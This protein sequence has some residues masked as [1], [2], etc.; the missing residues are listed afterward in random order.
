MKRICARIIF[1]PLPVEPDD[2]RLAH[3][4]SDRS[5]YDDAR[6]DSFEV[7]FR[8]GDGF[9]TE[10]SWTSLSVERGGRLLTPPLER[11]LLP[12]VLRE[13]LLAEGR[14]EERD[15]GL[16]DLRGGFYIGNAVRGLIAAELVGDPR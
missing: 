1:I 10:G 15:L 7:L 9:L 13:R 3:K 16:E 6:G 14:A 2:F 12:G 11:G 4:T 8:D 5:F